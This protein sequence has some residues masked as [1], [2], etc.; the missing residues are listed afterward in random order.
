MKCRNCNK[1]IP[2]DSIF[3]P[4]CGKKIET[5]TNIDKKVIPIFIGTSIILLILSILLI[6]IL[7]YKI[8]INEKVQDNFEIEYKTIFIKSEEADF[9]F[10]FDIPIYWKSETRLSKKNNLTEDEIRDFFYTGCDK[11]LP[12]SYSH[13]TGE[14]EC[15][16]IINMKDTEINNNFTD[17]R[18]S[19][20]PIASV[21][22][23]HILYGDSHA[24]QIDFYILKDYSYYSN[25]H[26]DTMMD[27]YHL[28]QDIKL[29][30]ID[31]K[32]LYFKPEKDSYGN[33]IINKESPNGWKIYYI[34]FNNNRDMFIISKQTEGSYEYEKEFEYLLKTLELNT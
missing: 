11:T 14:Y 19:N 33:I 27:N 13:Y 15:N 28:L 3:C 5:K 4:E 8:D 7:P 2:N 17:I 30:N 31:A 32:F 20:L 1:E 12:K 25:F 9:S 16:D 23:D 6:L 29:N 22:P 34:K 24:Q 18:L 26:I 21:S 10:N